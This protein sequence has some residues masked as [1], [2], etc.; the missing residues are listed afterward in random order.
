MTHIDRMIDERSNLQLLLAR[1]EVFMVSDTY[2][3]LPED[4]RYLMLEQRFVMREYAA[5]LTKR[6][7]RANDAVR[8]R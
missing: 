4:D 8:I 7:D 5:I 2:R 1:L 3:A 6:I